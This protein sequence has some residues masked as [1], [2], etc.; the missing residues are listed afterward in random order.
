MRPDNDWAEIEE[1]ISMSL[2]PSLPDGYICT[3]RCLGLC[4]T[5]ATMLA[6][7]SLQLQ[8]PVPICEACFNYVDSTLKIDVDRS[9]WRTS[10]H[11]LLCTWHKQNPLVR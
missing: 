9:I 3:W 11:E 10:Q 7:S 2:R 1:H 8:Q 6:P 4:L 5:K